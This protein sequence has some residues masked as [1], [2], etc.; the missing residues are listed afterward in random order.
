MYKHHRRNALKRMLAA[1]AVTAMPQMATATQPPTATQFP[2]ATQSPAT[3]SADQTPFRLRYLLGSCMFGM[4]NL[5][6]I[7]ACAKQTGATAV[8]LWPKP[9]GNQREQLD[10]LGEA[11]FAESLAKHGVQLGCITQYGLG[12]FGL[13]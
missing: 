10:E 5:D 9:H 13:Q 12:P 2:A 4:T 11:A 3:T 1:S 7:L 6:E 8:D